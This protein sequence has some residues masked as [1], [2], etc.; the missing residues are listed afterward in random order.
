MYAISERSYFRPEPRGLSSVATDNQ[1]VAVGAAAGSSAVAIGAATGAIAGPVGAAI[2]AGIGVVTMLVSDL[3]A[4]SGCGQTC[5]ETSS[6]ANQAEPLLSQNVQAYFAQPSP[7]SQSSQ[8]AAL[9]N[10]DSV[11]AALVAQCSQAGTGDAGKRCISDRQA[12]ACTWKQTSTSSLLSIP[13]E[14]QA[15]ACWNW[16]SGYR[17]PIANDAV[18]EDSSSALA[19]GA[20]DTSATA[21]SSSSYLVPALIAGAVL[22]GWLVL[23]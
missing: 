19:L 16:F 15:G 3:I 12:G 8:T 11:W 10:F 2:G 4:N 7:R 17:D 18:V 23:K 20:A 21:T 22:V 6:W 14:P 1:I 9:A 5:V 13:G